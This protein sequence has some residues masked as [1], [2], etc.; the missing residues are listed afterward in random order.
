[1]CEWY[2]MCAS[3]VRRVTL[4]GELRVPRTCRDYVIVNTT[5]QAASTHSTPVTAE[6]VTCVRA[7]AGHGPRPLALGRGQ[8]SLVGVLSCCYSPRTALRVR[9][10][11]YAAPLYYYSFKD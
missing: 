3:E 7:P 8:T 4:S 2:R 6:S 10:R 5:R 1:M 11:K 9:C